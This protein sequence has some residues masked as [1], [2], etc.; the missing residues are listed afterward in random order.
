MSLFDQLVIHGMPFVPKP[1]VGRVASRYVAG[2]TID[3]AVSTLKAMNEEGAMGTVDVLGEEVREP[4][5][6]VQAVDQYLE[7]LDRIEA[8][9]LDANVSIKP[10][11]LG[12]KIDEQLCIENVSRVVARAEQ[13]ENFVRIDM[14]DHTCTESTLN[15]Y[16]TVHAKHPSSVGVV[17]QA[18][19]HRTL[20]DIESL[21][22]LNPN[23]R[24]CKG[25]YREPRNIAWKDFDTV[26]QNFI[27]SMEKLMEGGAYVGI[28][29]HDPYLVCAGIRAADRLGLDRDQY[30]FQMLLGVD[31]ELRRIIVSNGHRLRVYVPYGSDWY[32][33]SIRRLREN[34]SVAH[35][36]IRAML[37]GNR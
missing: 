29:T 8:D 25:I 23:I 18:Y 2:E 36:V 9:S 34:P 20:P 12:L 14:E 11:M 19:L 6:A 26:R 37:T 27:N 5:K 3:E 13:L 16:R 15:L 7:L 10:T 22:E 35:H 30:E 33:Y 24:I 1:I 21:L 31:P 17:L 4:E 32:P 28:A